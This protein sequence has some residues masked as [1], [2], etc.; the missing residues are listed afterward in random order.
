MRSSYTQSVDVVSCCVG[1]LSA[2]SFVQL[3]SIFFRKQNRDL[4]KM[5]SLGE[6][7]SSIAC[8]HCLKTIILNA[9]ASCFCLLLPPLEQFIM[10]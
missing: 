4:E 7:F 10:S 3:E 2:S 1:R 9:Q 8:Y 6:S 5:T